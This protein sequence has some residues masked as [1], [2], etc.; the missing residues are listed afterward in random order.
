MQRTSDRTTQVDIVCSV[1]TCKKCN[2]AYK[3]YYI[4]LL[5]VLHA[6]NTIT[7]MHV[8]KSTFM[9]RGHDTMN[10]SLTNNTLRHAQLWDVAQFCPPEL[11]RLNLCELENEIILNISKY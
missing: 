8:H 4:V 7:K 9:R 3:K 5:I 11:V 10:V 2:N 1:K 6:E